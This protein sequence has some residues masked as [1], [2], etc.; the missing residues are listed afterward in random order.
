MAHSK[1]KNKSTETVSEKDLV[2]DLVD[3][4]VKITVIKMFKKN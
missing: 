1:E 4:D 3:K 2:A